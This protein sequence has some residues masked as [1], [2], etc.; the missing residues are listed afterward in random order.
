MNKEFN[1][2]ALYFGEDTKQFKVADFLRLVSD[3]SENFKKISAK[4]SSEEAKQLKKQ[5]RDEK[6][7]VPE[8]K[9]KI[10]KELDKIKNKVRQT[11]ARKTALKNMNF[12]KE[13]IREL[14]RNEEMGLDSTSIKK[15]ERGSDKN[16]RVRIME[17]LG[18]LD[19]EGFESHS[20]SPIPSSRNKKFISGFG[21]LLNDKVGKNRVTKARITKARITNFKKGGNESDE[22]DCNAMENDFIMINQPVKIN[23]P[24]D[25]NRATKSKKYFY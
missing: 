11:V 25:S 21:D 5:I 18:K 6:N 12:N 10:V 14:V 20:K 19:Q 17:K 4:L 8:N 22:E 1:D 2:T 13:K 3:F 23:K 9:N 7:K 15:H 24:S 16:E